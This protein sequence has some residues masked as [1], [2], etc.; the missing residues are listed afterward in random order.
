MP[1][2][3][4]SRRNANLSRRL[5]AALS[6]APLPMDEQL[7]RREENATSRRDRRWADQLREAQRKATDT[8]ASLV[9]KE[10][11]SYPDARQETVRPQA[12]AA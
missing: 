12:L 4:R 3:N 11:E 2:P 5:M 10:H 8:G 1:H 7:R 9:V 6:Q